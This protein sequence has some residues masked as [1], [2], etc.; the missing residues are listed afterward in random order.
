MN[1]QS[2]GQGPRQ[3]TNGQPE[4][5]VAANPLPYL[6]ILTDGAF[7]SDKPVTVYSVGLHMHTRG[8]RGRVAIQRQAGGEECL[9]E[10]PRWDF[11]W[12]GSYGL[13]TPRIFNPG[14]KFYLECHFDNSA[15][16][17]PFVDGKRV[18]PRDLN[19]GEG[20][21]DEMCLTGFYLT[22]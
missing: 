10:V 19:W 11:H 15:A 13:T 1:R 5:T 12:Q 7:V 3:K 16:N 9:L 14:D 22:Q 2:T 21:H 18:E 17:Q 8:T 20:T 6:P 4:Q